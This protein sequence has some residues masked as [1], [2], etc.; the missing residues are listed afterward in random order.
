MLL[1]FARPR[2]GEME[3][4]EVD[5][6]D[7]HLAGCADCAA[8]A[9]DARCFDDA[10]GKAMRQ[11]DVPD[12]LKATLHAK[13]DADHA[14]RHRR[15]MFRAVRSIAAAAAVLILFGAAYAWWRHHTRPEV[16]GDQVLAEVRKPR[17]D[18]P[19]SPEQLDEAFRK[20][21][22]TTAVPREMKYDYFMFHSLADFQG[23][24]VPSLVFLQKSRQRYAQV[25][26]LSDRQFNFK[27]LGNYQSP[28][29]VAYE[30]VKVVLSRDSRYAYV[31]VYTGR[32][33]D[34]LLP[35]GGDAL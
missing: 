31:I 17:D 22:V 26:I 12:R 24:Q 18:G 34:W 16:T 32:D 4:A 30:N 25:L 8:L 19:P 5:A 13:L 33:L 21:G 23:Y 29:D 15:R 10:L 9:R 27:K 14:D 28:H 6:L 3:P 7:A 11:V 1:E 2:A 35:G 20:M